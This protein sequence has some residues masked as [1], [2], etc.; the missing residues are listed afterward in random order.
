MPKG[1]EDAHVDITGTFVRRQNRAPANA[2][3]ARPPA[4]YALLDLS[5]GGVF[6]VA[7]QSV[8]LDF[9]I[10]N[11]LDAAYRDYLSRYRYFSDDP[12]RSFVLRAQIPFGQFANE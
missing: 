7:G 2:D 1:I 4:P 12:G 8:T 3:Y 6:A 10:H 5:F 9:S 11:V